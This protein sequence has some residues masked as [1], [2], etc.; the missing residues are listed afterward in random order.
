MEILPADT[1]LRPVAPDTPDITATTPEPHM[2][3]RRVFPR[4]KL[5]KPI[6]GYVEHNFQRYAGSVYDL[7]LGGF[8]LFVRDEKAETFAHDGASDFGE[9]AHDGKPIGGFGT[10]VVT[11]ELPGGVAIGFKWDEYVAHDDAKVIN[12]LIDE[13]VLRRAA[14]AV[15]RNGMV[16]EL[17]GH[18]SSALASDL[19]ASIVA[20]ATRLSLARCTSIDSSG[21]DVLLNLVKGGVVI[22]EVSGDVQPILARFHLLPEGRI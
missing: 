16:T 13:L 8:L 17:A 14:G 5:V 7:S 18:V 12:A 9:I 11:R 19:F 2:D 20:G 3:E 4:Y 6:T 21:L 10:I 22:G 1:R 15:V